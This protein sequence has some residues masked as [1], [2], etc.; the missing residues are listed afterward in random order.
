MNVPLPQH[1]EEYVSSLLENGRSRLYVRA[2]R[3][4]LRQL[5]QHCRFSRVKDL[6][7]TPVVKFLKELRDSGHSAGLVRAWRWRAAAFSKWLAETGRAPGD[8]LNPPMPP[9]PEETVTPAEARRTFGW[10]HTQL[11]RWEADCP[12]LPGGKLD[13]ILDV[14]RLQHVCLS[15]P[16]GQPNGKRYRLAD[17]QQIADS[18][19]RGNPGIHETADG[20]ALNLTQAEDLIQIDCETLR[21]HTRASPLLPEGHLP[22][23]WLRSKSTG[24]DE[25]TVLLTDLR[26]LQSA[27]DARLLAGKR[28]G[29]KSGA[30]LARADGC[31][32]KW[33]NYLLFA[34]RTLGLVQSQEALRAHPCRIRGRDQSNLL[35][36]VLYDA[37]ELDR[38]RGAQ[39]LSDYLKG[40][41][42]QAA[43]AVYTAMMRGARHPEIERLLAQS[44]GPTSARNAQGGPAAAVGTPASAGNDGASASAEGGPDAAE[45][46]PGTP[47][48]TRAKKPRRGPAPT[49]Q[50]LDIGKLCYDQ[51]KIGTLRRTICR[52]IREQFNGRIMGETDVT[53]YARR[54]SGYQ[55]PPLP[56]PV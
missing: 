33:M 55:E 51:L 30:E 17:L 26:R 27:R 47:Q 49:K 46:R 8:L 25:L 41:L 13:P 21:G 40:L 56:W 11:Q 28:N 20:M 22:H 4:R 18:M 43:P 37:R 9:P 24:K 6:R 10:T 42:K 12:H 14:R 3:W 39:R 52:L 23:K 45:S 44:T 31:S 19:D 36:V 34:L 2:A 15:G 7:P 32:K 38:R 29:W 54:Y 1:V 5:L 35:P 16:V 53:N 50:T 48:P